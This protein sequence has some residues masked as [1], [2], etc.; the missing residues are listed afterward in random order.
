MENCVQVLG[1]AQ[2]WIEVIVRT[3]DLLYALELVLGGPIIPEIMKLT[4]I[5]SA[6]TSSE[7]IGQKPKSW[8]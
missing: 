5:D 1:T 7:S 3:C 6:L 8:V 4:L 2:S